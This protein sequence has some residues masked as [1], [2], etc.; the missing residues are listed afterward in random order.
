M[1]VHERGQVLITQFRQAG[2]LQFKAVKCAITF[3]DQVLLM[4]PYKPEDKDQ[5]KY[6]NDVREWLIEGY[7]EIYGNTAPLP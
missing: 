2:I 7:K 4:L 1:K 6:W 5:I 3:C